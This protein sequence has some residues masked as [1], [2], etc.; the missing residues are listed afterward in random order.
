MVRCCFVLSLL[1]VVAG[2][3]GPLKAQSESVYRASTVGD[4][5]TLGGGLGLSVT[6]HLM[7][8][9]TWKFDPTTFSS[10]D[11]LSVNAFDRPATGNWSPTL[12]RMSDVTLVGAGVAGLGLMLADRPVR[13]EWMVWTL[14]AGEVFFL[15]HGT[16]FITKNATERIRPFA[17]NQNVSVH[18]KQEGSIYQSFFSGH[19]SF[20][21]AGSFFAAK[22]Y[23]DTHPGSKWRIAVWG[24]AGLLSGTTAWLRVKAGKHFPT[25]VI[26]GVAA[27]ALIGILV[28]EIHRRKRSPADASSVKF[29]FGPA[30]GING[31][32][33]GLRF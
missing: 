23:H 8:Q 17:Y 27:G 28:P 7:G 13:Q 15:T 16:T 5:V 20:A 19:S 22:L 30:W 21:A 33:V 6:G 26:T 12:S 32:R 11:P 29:E 14:M 4:L 25:D 2:F 18:E 31:L 9:K 10:L 3:S 24:G 1:L